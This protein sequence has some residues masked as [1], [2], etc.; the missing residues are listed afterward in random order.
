MTTLEKCIKTELGEHII[1]DRKVCRLYRKNI[2]LNYK[3][4]WE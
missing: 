1:F 3:E 4:G 2:D